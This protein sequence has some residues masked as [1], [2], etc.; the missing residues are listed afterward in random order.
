MRS[1]KEMKELILKV[2][3][4]DE[5]IRAVYL[6]GSR[7]NPN[8]PKDIFQDYD[9]VYVVKET[10][11]FIKDKNWL[12]VFGEQLYMQMPEEM[13]R[14][15]GRDCSPEECYGYLIQL[16]DGNRIDFHL[17]IAAWAREDIRMD[18]M[19]IVWLDKD[20]IFS[21][22]PPTT[23]ED[24]WVKKPGQA[25]YACCCN[26]FWWLLN[27]IGKG[28]WR[29]EIPYV[30]D[31]LNINMRPELIKMLSWETGIS[32]DFSCS[33]GKAGK[34]LK[35]YMSSER[36]GRFL[37]TYPMA[38]LEVIWNAMFT[39]CDLFDET[40]RAVGQALGYCYEEKEAHNSRLFFD[41]TYELPDS[42]KEI[43]MVRRMRKQDVDEVARIWLETNLTAHS[44]IPADWFRNHLEQVRVRLAEAE[45][46]VYE[47][48]RGILGFAGMNGGYLEGIFVR[49]GV[50]SQGIGQSLMQRCKD[51]YF[52]LR[53][54]VY[55]KNEGAVA[56]Y[57][58]EGFQVSKKDRDEAT[59]QPEYEM[60]WRKEQ[61]LAE[62]ENL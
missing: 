33:V 57:M 20:G 56:F 60:L 59:G 10:A 38:N 47:D 62:H 39:M 34:Y 2:A 45:V 27:N 7:A 31:M 19:C 54:H 53:L 41:C 14:M 40:A 42:A 9:F 6:N 4:E 58:R 35:R 15:L 46:Y 13:D 23:D 51:N 25:E 3:R 12:A 44:F 28:L 22:I 11:S 21:S 18:R 36:Y 1:E 30:M 8:A 24:H 37:N 49:E 17:E 52:K 29:G 16:A 32:N 61:V 43:C 55:C 5:R 48:N 26:E 50:Q